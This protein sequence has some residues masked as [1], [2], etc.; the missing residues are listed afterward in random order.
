MEGTASKHT[1]EENRGKK[2]YIRDIVELI[3]Y[4]AAALAI[5]FL[6][7]TYIGQRTEVI[8]SSMYPT[9]EHGDNLIVDKISYRFKD[10]ERFD[11]IV[12]PSPD[13]KD[14]IYIKR[15][16]GLPGEKIRI[17]D[18]IIYVDSGAGEYVLDENYGAEMEYYGVAADGIELGDDEYFVLGDN[19]NLSKDSRFDVV[20]NIHKDDIIGRA[21]VQIWPLSEFGFVKNK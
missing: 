1:S 4:I 6:I 20:G 13:E 18:G 19:R 11:I 16:I 2:N 7:T 10:P 3:I 9:L 21:W 5:A 8:G 17:D 15:I 12:F 14:K